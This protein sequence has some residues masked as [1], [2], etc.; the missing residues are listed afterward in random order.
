MSNFI[1]DLMKGNHPRILEENI[2]AIEVVKLSNMSEIVRILCIED[3]SSKGKNLAI[4]VSN[5][6]NTE[7]GLT[8]IY[9]QIPELFRPNRLASLYIEIEK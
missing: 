7:E 3:S 5:V 6:Q 2:H 1:T 4:S 9:N 8:K